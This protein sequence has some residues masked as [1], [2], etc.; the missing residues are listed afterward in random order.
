MR[1]DVYNYC[2]TYP[3]YQK[4]KNFFKNKY[5]FLLEKVAESTKWSRV[6]LDCWGP[7]T[8]KIKNDWDYNIYLLT[9]ANP[10]T[11]WFEYAQIFGLPTEQV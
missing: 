10:V 4:Y 1:D 7:K 6:N 9:M 5:G 3:T 2:K 8:I 11:G